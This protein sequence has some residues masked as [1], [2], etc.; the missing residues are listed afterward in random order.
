MVKQNVIGCSFVRWSV[1]FLSIFFAQT[2]KTQHDMICKSFTGSTNSSCM[3]SLNED[4]GFGLFYLSVFFSFCLTITCISV[5]HFLFLNCFYVCL[6]SVCL[7][8]VHLSFMF[9]LFNLLSFSMKNLKF[10]I[11]YPFCLSH[12][13]KYFSYE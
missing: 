7:F 11:F 8:F 6:L 4:L 1:I 12:A 9:C 2:P 10:Y 13:Y 5:C 3:S